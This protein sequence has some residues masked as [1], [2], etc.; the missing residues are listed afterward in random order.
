[1]SS[2]FFV[3]SLEK[4]HVFDIGKNKYEAIYEN[5]PVWSKCVNLAANTH[6]PL[7]IIS[8]QS[9]GISSYKISS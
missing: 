8:D 5:K 3:L 2:V 9:G 6:Q 7:L 1:M 4:S